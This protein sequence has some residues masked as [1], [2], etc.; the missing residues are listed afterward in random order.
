MFFKFYFKIRVKYSCGHPYEK[1][2]NIEKP[3]FRQPGQNFLSFLQNLKCK[4][5]QNFHVF[6]AVSPKLRWRFGLF[7]DWPIRSYVNA[8]F[9]I[10]SHVILITWGPESDM[11]KTFFCRICSSMVDKGPGFYYHRDWYPMWQE[12]LT[13][14]GKGFSLLMRWTYRCLA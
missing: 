8:T 9:R 5:I 7:I 14:F 10:L 1:H 2:Q 13:V 12:K 3:H 11:G 4:S 6:T